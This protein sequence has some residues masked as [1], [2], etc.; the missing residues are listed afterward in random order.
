MPATMASTV[1]P[2]KKD[3]PSAF[4]SVSD[5]CRQSR[6]TNGLPVS[7]LPVSRLAIQN[8]G[9]RGNM[10]MCTKTNTS[11]LFNLK[12]MARGILMSSWK[13]HTGMIPIKIPKAMDLDFTSILSPGDRNNFHIFSQVTFLPDG[14]ADIV[15][16]LTQVSL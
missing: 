12:K 5:I 14:L 7:I 8:N 1:P 4:T 3:M 10:L 6:I 9:V 13:P 11:A 2:R 16:M 15:T